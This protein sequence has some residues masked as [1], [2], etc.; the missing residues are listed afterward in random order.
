M[1]TKYFLV[2]LTVQI[3]IGS[4]MFA[5]LYFLLPDGPTGPQGE[6]GIQGVQGMQGPVGPQGEI[7]LTGKTGA[8]GP[9]GEDGEDG[10]DGAMGVQGPQGEQGER[11]EVGAMGL[12][13]P[14]GAQG[15]QGERGLQGDAGLQGPQGLMG[16]QGEIGP[17]GFMGPPG[18]SPVVDGTL[19]LK[20]LIIHTP[21]DDLYLILEGGDGD[22]V[23]VI[24]WT[25]D[26]TDPFADASSAIQG[27][28]TRGMI[29]SDWDDV[30]RSWSE[31]CLHNGWR[32]C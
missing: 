5:G 30:S 17:R 25:R 16:L 6:Q 15:P 28:T 31:Y 12:Q 7:G 11:G 3:I 32:S 10:D 27:S 24:S 2:A 18:P 8:E 14:Q 20:K 29:F 23:P 21:G 13:G 9:Q 19:T 4:A 26:G 22:G 1:Q